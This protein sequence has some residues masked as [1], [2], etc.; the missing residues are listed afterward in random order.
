MLDDL[1]WRHTA[2]QTC[3]GTARVPQSNCIT[4]DV[5]RLLCIVQRG[6]VYGEPYLW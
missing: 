6:L 1:R 5:L 3:G 2:R 4:Q